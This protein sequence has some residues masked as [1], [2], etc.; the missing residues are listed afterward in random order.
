MAPP[1]R[2]PGKVR[3]LGQ[4]PRAWSQ[5]V[6]SGFCSETLTKGSSAW[7]AGEGLQ[8]DRERTEG[9]TGSPATVCPWE[10]WSS[11]PYCR[12]APRLAPNWLLLLLP[13]LLFSVGEGGLFY[14][15]PGEELDSGLFL[16]LPRHEEVTWPFAWPFPR[17][18]TARDKGK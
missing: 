17:A 18:F 3:E 13:P 16:C 7:N 2:K 15:P 12:S 1:G 8:E 9:Q 10:Q 6:G 11:H 14:G 5:R 4:G